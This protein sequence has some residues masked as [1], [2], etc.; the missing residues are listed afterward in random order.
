MIVNV[1]S[2]FGQ[3]LK[4]YQDLLANM[5]IAS[6]IPVISPLAN[7]NMVWTASVTPGRYFDIQTG[8]SIT[9]SSLD[10]Y[11]NVYYGCLYLKSYCSVFVAPGEATLY[12]NN[13][14]AAANNYIVEQR[15]IA[16][17]DAAI[18]KDREFSYLPCAFK[19]LR[20]VSNVTGGADFTMT[21][22]IMFSG[23]KISY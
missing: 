7:V 9:S 16:A 20:I 12:L 17:V 4:F 10:D 2:F 6:R 23:V 1:P 13:G 19:F 15:N 11:R 21:T 3:D 14:S 5:G 18:G 22:N 8:A